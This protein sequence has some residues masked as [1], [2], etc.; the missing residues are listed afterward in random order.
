MPRTKKLP[1][2][3]HLKLPPPATSAK[4]REDQLIALATDLAAKRL[5]DGS[6]S[7]QE[8]VHFLRMGS[9]REKMERDRLSKENELLTVKT[10]AI[11]SQKRQDEL[12]EAAISA[13]KMYSGAQMEEI[14]D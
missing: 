9:V 8:I 12:Y 6:A 3:Q 5:S 14:Y 4:E 11:R 7:S 10:D 2:S 13:M 1:A